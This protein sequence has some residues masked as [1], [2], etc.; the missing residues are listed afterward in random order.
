M[1]TYHISTDPV[2]L[3]PDEPTV[4]T[5]TEGSLSIDGKE[6]DGSTTI[7]GPTQVWGEG[8]LHTE[9]VP[10]EPEVKVKTTKIKPKKRGKKK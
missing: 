2:V 1:T 3:H 5:V 10:P 6:I 4:L 8:T 9:P 7:D